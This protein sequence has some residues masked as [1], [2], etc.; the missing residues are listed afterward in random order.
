M[1]KEVDGQLL[2]DENIQPEPTAVELKKELEVRASE[3]EKKLLEKMKAY[4]GVDGFDQAAILNL[5][6]F[7]EGEFPEKFKA[8]EF[9]K[10]NGTGCP[11]MHTRLYVRRMGQYARFDKLMVQT[12]Q[13]S[14]T[15][16]ALT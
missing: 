15:G 1:Q 10:Y 4:G 13:D 2:D 11:N 3:M 6:K 8:P 7:E 16:P 5:P 9:E 12:F 14:L